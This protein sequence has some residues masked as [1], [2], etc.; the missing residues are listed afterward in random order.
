M[1]VRERNRCL[2]YTDS[3]MGRNTLDCQPQSYKLRRARGEKNVR[4]TPSEK[5]TVFHVISVSP[6]QDTSIF[7]HRPVTVVLN[8]WKGQRGVEWITLSTTLICPCRF[9]IITNPVSGC[10]W[11]TIVVVLWLN[12]TEPTS[13]SASQTYINTFKTNA[14]PH[15]KVVLSRAEKEIGAFEC[16][17]WFDSWGMFLISGLN[18]NISKTGSLNQTNHGMG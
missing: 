11:K 4:L 17:Y 5:T 14:D 7:T 1:G 9:L 2:W 18:Y 16:I 6:P 10:P 12:C 15:G 3:S 8:K 13:L